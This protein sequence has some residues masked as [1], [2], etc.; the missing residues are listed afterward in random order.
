MARAA[1]LFRP[2]VAD[3]DGVIESQPL[4]PGRELLASG[5]ALPQNRVAG[6][7]IGADHAAV[8]ALVLAVVATETTYGIKMR[9]VGGIG[10]P[11]DF[12]RREERVVVG[13]PQVR[14]GAFDRL[15]LAC[16]YLGVAFLVI[17]AQAAIDS[18]HGLLPAGVT[19]RKRR[20]A[21]LL[22]EWKRGIDMAIGQR[23]VHAAV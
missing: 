14:D 8:H 9:V 23:H 11:A 4:R 7:A 16:I 17:T 20:H 22:D 13:I 5:L 6:V 10:V 19:R 2:G 18:L 15:P 3:V 21:L 12:H 1:R